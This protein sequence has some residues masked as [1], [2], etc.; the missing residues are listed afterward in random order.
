M[1]TGQ[2]LWWIIEHATEG[3]FLGY[4]RQRRTREMAPLFRRAD[5]RKPAMLFGSIAAAAEELQYITVDER[6]YQIVPLR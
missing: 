5:D 4:A 2:T 1:K 6:D 3:A